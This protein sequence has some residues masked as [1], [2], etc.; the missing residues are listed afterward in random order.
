MILDK[1]SSLIIGI[2]IIMSSFILGLF[3]YITFDSENIRNISKGYIETE[4]I[5]N[6]DR[7]LM[8][9]NIINIEEAAKYLNMTESDIKKVIITEKIMRESQNGF[10][11]KMLPYFKINDEFY[12]YKAQLVLWIFEV[13]EEQREYDF[14][15]YLIK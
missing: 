2:S 4:A 13:S 11:G 9:S 6:N 3:I 1:K 12:F 15:K 7:F 14:K 5:E 8:N 10:N